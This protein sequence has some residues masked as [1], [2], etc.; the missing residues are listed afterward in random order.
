MKTNKKN[1]EKEKT[2]EKAQQLIS[3]RKEVRHCF[4]QSQFALEMERKGSE[5]QVQSALGQNT[6][7]T[8]LDKVDMTREVRQIVM[9]L[10]CE[11]VPTTVDF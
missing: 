11:L 6:L 5:S 4:K 2:K 1:E 8:H 7:C 3:L 9:K 10:N